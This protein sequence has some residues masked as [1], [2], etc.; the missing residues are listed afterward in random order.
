MENQKVPPSYDCEECSIGHRCDR[1]QQINTLTNLPANSED[2]ILKHC[3]SDDFSKD[4]KAKIK[5]FAFFMAEDKEVIEEYLQG[6][7]LNLHAEFT[8]EL[9]S[10]NNIKIG[11]VK[12]KIQLGEKFQEL[13]EEVEMSEIEKWSTFLNNKFSIDLTRTIHN[14]MRL[15]M[16]DI[17]EKYY[18]LG[19]FDLIKIESAS[20]TAKL[21]FNEFMENGITQDDL[22]LRKN[23]A[24]E[25]SRLIKKRVEY[26]KNLKEMEEKGLTLTEQEQDA[27]RIASD[28][29]F[30]PTQ[31]DIVDFKEKKK[32]KV[33][34]VPILSERMLRS[35]LNNQVS[36][37][38]LTAEAQ[39]AN[40]REDLSEILSYLKNT[41]PGDMSTINRD[42]IEDILEKANSISSILAAELQAQTSN[43]PVV[44]E[45]IEGESSQC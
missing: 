10:G 41:P 2:V 34:L 36:K 29:G 9:N 23:N 15:A 44:V 28:N 21:T 8:N 25:W 3:M 24:D 5:K 27:F 6:L 42:L 35:Q 37:N 30:R 13:K 12:I 18:T 11:L 40:Y 4:I 14:Y 43:S 26:V 45:K 16:A 39:L 7:A 22:D 33:D 32:N 1:S 38:I 17:D 31:N 20:R 19:I